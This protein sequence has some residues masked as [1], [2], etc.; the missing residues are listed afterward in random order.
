MP[1]TATSRDVLVDFGVQMRRMT[2][3]STMHVRQRLIAVRVSD[4]MAQERGKPARQWGHYNF[5]LLYG[6]L[7]QGR[8]ADA[9]HDRNARRR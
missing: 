3:G 1:D 2:S 8:D 6:L 4:A 5:W 9:L 7:Q